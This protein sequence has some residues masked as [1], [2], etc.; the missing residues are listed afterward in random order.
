MQIDTR[1][2]G[3][4]EIDE[5]KVL[6]FK[7]GLPGFEDAKKFILVENE[8]KD[9]PFM[10]LQGVDKPDLAF[11]IVNPF[12]IKKDYDINISGEAASQLGIEKAEDVSVFSIVVVPEDI[13]KISM[14]LKAPV[15]INTKNNKGAQI[16]LDTDEY[17]VRHYILEELQRQEVKRDACSDT[18]EGTVHNH[19]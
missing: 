10:W 5:S 4:M 18:E 2:F 7:E 16:I 1:D 12:M 3:I 14:N 11:A 19:K 8:E 6:D 9:S 17:S 13:T 15:I